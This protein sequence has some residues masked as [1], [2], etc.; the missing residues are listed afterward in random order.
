MN[1]QLIKRV[2]ECLPSPNCDDGCKI[3]HFVF[4][5]ITTEGS[6]LTSNLAQFA[7][8][9]SASLHT[10]SRLDEGTPSL[11]RPFEI[12]LDRRIYSTFFK[13]GNSWKSGVERKRERKKASAS[14]SPPNYIGRLGGFI[15]TSTE[16]RYHFLLV[17]VLDS[18]LN[19]LIQS[20]VFNLSVYEALSR[21]SLLCRAGAASDTKSGIVRL[22]QL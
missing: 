13:I 15:H 18:N 9:R 21:S 14:T 12:D 22:F 5:A 1:I 19:R 10:L 3:G 11:R 8:Y 2:S 16:K 4:K 7:M 6:M 20:C 17:K